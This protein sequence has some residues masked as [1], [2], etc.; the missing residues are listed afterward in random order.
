MAIRNN[1]TGKWW[2]G[3]TFNQ[4]SAQDFAAAWAD[5]EWTYAGLTGASLT[6]GT[7]Y[8][9]TSQGVDLATNVE[10]FYNA[11]GSTFTFDNGR[12]TAG[13]TWP[14]AVNSGSLSTLAGT[15]SDDFAGV[16]TVEISMHDQTQAP[17]QGW[18]NGVSF[19][20]GAQQWIAASTNP[21]GTSWT[22]TDSDLPGALVSGKSYLVVARATDKAGNPQNV[23]TVNVS[24]RITLFD[25]D[26]PTAGV[27]TPAASTAVFSLAT[28]AGTADDPLGAPGAS[29]VGAIALKIIDSVNNVLGDGDDLYWNGVSFTAHSSNTVAGSGTTAWSYGAVPGWA[30]NRRYAVA[31]AAADNAGNVQ[32]PSSTNTFIIDFSTPNS[33]VTLPVEGAGYS[34]SNPLVTISGTAADQAVGAGLGQVEISIRLDHAPYGDTPPGDEDRWLNAARTAFDSVGEV[35]FTTG[36]FPFTSWTFVAPTWV[37]GKNYVIRTRATDAAGVTRNVEATLPLRHFSVDILPPE[38]VI[39]DPDD[40]SAFKTLA[41]LSGTASDDASGVKKVEVCIKSFGSDQI[42]D[43]GNIGQCALGGDDA[44]WDGNDASPAFKTTL[45]TWT[46]ASGQDSWT[47]SGV[48]WGAVGRFR[49]MTRGT[50]NAG[51]EETPGAG[52]VFSI[53]NNPP[54]ASF[55]VPANGAGYNSMTAMSGTASDW[56]GSGGTVLTPADSG[57]NATAVDVAISSSPNYNTWW[58]GSTQWVAQ[59]TPRWIARPFVGNSSGTWSWNVGLPGDFTSGVRY[60]ALVRATDRAGNVQTTFAP[61]ISSNVFSFD[62]AAPVSTFTVPLNQT[63]HKSLAVIAG[64]TGDDFSGIDAANVKLQISYYIDP[65]TYYWTGSNAPAYTFNA[66]PAVDLPAV[67][68]GQTTGTWSYTDATLPGAWVSGRTYTLNVRARD[69]ATNQEVGG[70]TVTFL[71]DRE[72]TAPVITV[73]TAGDFRGPNKTLPTIGGTAADLPANVVA[74]LSQVQIRIKRSSN[75]GEYWNIGGGGWG[76]TV[77]SWNVATGTATWTYPMPNPM[78]DAVQYE[79]NVRS[80]DL[81]GN[82]SA[83]ATTAFVYDDNIPTLQ[84]QEPGSDFEP[85]PLSILS[86]TANDPGPLGLKGELTLVELSIQINPPTGNFWTGAGFLNPGEQFLAAA[87]LDSWSFTGSTP[88]WVS[89]TQYKVRVRAKDGA[90]NLSAVASRTFTFDSGLSTTTITLP[91]SN[92]PQ[93]SLTMISG[94]ASDN[95]GIGSV[96]V[97]IYDSVQTKFWNNALQNWSG[98]LTADTAWFVSSATLSDWTVWNAT[99]TFFT[100]TTYQVVARAKDKAG[101]YDTTASTRTFLYDDTKPLSYVGLPANNAL[102]NSL[103]TITGTAADGVFGSGVNTVAVAIRNNATG[104][105]WN[106]GTFNQGSL[107]SFNTT[108]ADPEWTYAPAGLN[109]AM[110]SGASYY[111]TSQAVDLATNVEAFYNA[112]GSTFT[113]DSTPPT[114]GIDSPV[115]GRFYNALGS[116][117]GA[118]SDLISLSTVAISIRDASAAGPNNCY[119]PGAGFSAACP[120]WFKA[121]GSNNPWNYAF[122]SQPWSNAHLYVILSSATDLAGNPQVAL[123]SAGF[124]FDVRQPTA[125]LTSPQWINSSVSEFT[126]TSTDSL[127]GIYSLTIAVSSSAG[128]AN[129]WWDGGSFSGA[130]SVFFAT[131]TYVPGAV[132]DDW[133]WN[134]PP[135][136][137]GVSYLIR[138]NTTDRAGN[139]WILDQPTSVI[140]DTA[141]PTALITAPAHGGFYNALAALSGGSADNIGVST[142]ALSIQDVSQAAPNCYAYTSNAFNAACPNFFPAQGAVGAWTFGG[143]TWSDGRRYVVT[144]RATDLA[145]NAQSVF[146][147]GVSSHS[148]IFDSRSPNSFI[149]SPSAGQMFADLPSISGTASGVAL[150]TPL[151][152]VQLSIGQITGTTT[153]YLDGASLFNGATEYF[154]DTLFVGMASGTWSYATPVLTSGKYYLI[155]SKAVDAAGNAENFAVVVSTMFLYDRTKSTGAVTGLAGTS[156]SSPYH[157]S[158][159]PLTGSAFDGPLAASAGLEDRGS[160]GAQLRIYDAGLGQWWNSSGGD[161]NQ[162]TADSAWFN[163]SAGVSSAWTYSH[164][165]LDGK[166]TSGNRYL[167]QFRAKDKALPADF[168]RGP[169]SDG[170]DSNFT[171]GVDS[172]AFI[173]DKTPP[174]SRITTPSDGSVIKTLA[175]IG[176]TASDVLVNG[177]SAGISSAGLIEFSVQELT[178]NSSFLTCPAYSTFTSVGE[179]WCAAATLVGSVWSRPAPPLLQDGFTYRIRVRARD[180]AVPGG[181][182]ETVI[183]SI[184]FT[185][186]TTAPGVAVTAPAPGSFRSSVAGL[187]GTVT[188]NFGVSV[189]S[190]AVQELASGY[191]WN[192]S[193]FTAPGTKQWYT[194]ALAGGPVNYTFSFVDAGLTFQDNYQYLIDARAE[195]TAGNPGNL[196]A[197]ASFTFDTTQPNSNMTVVPAPGAFLSNLS[198][199]SGVASDPNANASGVSKTEVYIQRPDLQYWQVG[200]GWAGGGAVWLPTTGAPAWTKTT[201]LPP[202]TTPPRACSTVCAKRSVRAR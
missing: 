145:V 184:T 32:I 25:D 148:F 138:T 116:I 40:G 111:I 104:L 139:S 165:A 193:T 170:A 127:S 150:L 3:G 39:Q 194:A 38:T 50:D 35:F 180:N 117:S 149:A 64:T 7:S 79:L 158:L 85:A 45:S 48:S 125:T 69:L 23:F 61:G 124:F 166:L 167:I 113:F 58:D 62:S 15:A 136:T 157:I 200:G 119:A 16:D 126:G 115:D 152:R 105:W 177:S 65:S 68:V 27:Q 108:W 146:N 9:V 14:N 161:F 4:D 2:N 107:T 97:R 13:L 91:A 74:A 129:S 31:V 197:L 86:G 8:Y 10:P 92:A 24:S 29:D 164:A 71:F 56:S 17:T 156:P 163:A 120:A 83:S 202:S 128:A 175:S 84:L 11:R 201:N 183:S 114:S 66:G 42:E 123:S 46:P 47:Y 134:R 98:G 90:D 73:P 20:G 95:A 21:A 54:T 143:V 19:T 109:A 142:I 106:G 159:D 102:V 181:N 154:H 169:S 132:N 26:K 6:S 44:I 80:L 34:A 151:A 174:L 41:T 53:D 101:N 18:W 75:G 72:T 121:S 173:A 131:T 51:N 67:F 36:T 189:A 192:G 190:I 171:L 77:E 199:I 82:L 168:N 176:G 118:A 1:A 49:L 160:G 28:I 140:Y 188:G 81:A 22:Y 185:Y 155:R 179:S 103:T 99:F 70:S 96:W 100:D 196:G 187:A 195:D 182:L 52:N 133:T 137:N 172:I 89:G 191:W 94:T 30:S 78:D 87:G 186:N 93:N 55:V 135:L 147:A 112:R 57:I 43:P 162:P 76:T 153:D 12:P 110:T 37:S 63:P 178:P 141:V 59:G 88:T 122:V 60:R 144:A 198:A 33:Y 130:G 5:P